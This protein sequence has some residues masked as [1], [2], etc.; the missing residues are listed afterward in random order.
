MVARSKTATKRSGYTAFVA[1]IA[2][3]VSTSAVALQ[4]AA[5]LGD[6]D[7]PS[8]ARWRFHLAAAPASQPDLVALAAFDGV[9]SASSAETY[10]I[11]DALPQLH[12]VRTIINRA[13][14]RDL[15]PGIHL[16]S[17]PTVVATPDGGTPRSLVQLASLT[18]EN[19]MIPF[20]VEPKPVVAEKHSGFARKLAERPATKEEARSRK[21][22]AEA[23]YFEA[24]GEPESGQY[25]VAQVVMNRV[26]SPYYPDS[27]CG[28]V[29][30]NKHMRNRCQFSFACDRIPDRVTNRESWKLATRIAYEVMEQ[31]YYLGDVGQSTHYHA[32]YVRPRWIRDMNKEAHIG[33][34]IFYTV[35]NWTNEGV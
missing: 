14:K 34:H 26:R 4:D 12:R 6:I 33:R 10:E 20:F 8:A 9:S 18:P 31:G 5:S 25:A 19:V 7:T 23:V 13:A 15:L 16:A 27:V 11:R 3:L 1:C 28:V 35:R 21:C 2:M 24:R 29:Y 17:A 30:Q 22:L 32:T